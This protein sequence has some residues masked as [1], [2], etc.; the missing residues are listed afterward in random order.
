MR[1]DRNKSLKTINESKEHQWTVQQSCTADRL[2]SLVRWSEVPTP[3]RLRG[4]KSR[5]V[6]L[7][8]KE[9]VHK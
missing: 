2:E 5:T 8:I 4:R 1:T 7:S 3:K 9:K 6:V